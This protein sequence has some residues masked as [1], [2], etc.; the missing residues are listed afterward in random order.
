MAEV[1]VELGLGLL[2]LQEAAWLDL[3]FLPGDELLDE[4]TKFTT[5][6]L[7][8][9]SKLCEAFKEL[10]IDGIDP[11]KELVVHGKSQ[12]LALNELVD[13]GLYGLG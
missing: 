10:V 11:F 4:G 13:L 1:L 5:C 7:V 6:P 8:D 12:C 3:H 9:K 2:D